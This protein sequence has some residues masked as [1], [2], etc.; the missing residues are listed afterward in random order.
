MKELNLPPFYIGQRVIALTSDPKGGMR[1]KGKEYPILDIRECK[2]GRYTVDIG[3]RGVYAVVICSSC[4][5]E[6][7]RPTVTEWHN[8]ASFA[9]IQENFQ[10]ITLEKVL[11]EETK[12]I[13]VN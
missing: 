13:S 9:P 6:T 1:I 12:L 4:R 2:C 8:A 11:E 5:H 3:E 10:H 7:P